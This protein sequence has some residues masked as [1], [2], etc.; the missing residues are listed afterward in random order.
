[1]DQK[2]SYCGLICESC[3]I[4]LVTQTGDEKKNE[5]LASQISTEA[6]KFTAADVYCYGCFDVIK[7][8]PKLSGQCDIRKCAIGKNLENCGYCQSYPC[9][10]FS[11]HVPDGSDE[12]K[13]LDAVFNKVFPPANKTHV[14]IIR[15]EYS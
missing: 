9:R 8:N 15:S 12:R 4:L 11:D 7:E 5:E 6:A 1:M 13:R 10:Y 3:P 2:L 14:S